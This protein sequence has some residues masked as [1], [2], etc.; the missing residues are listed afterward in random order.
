M[1]TRTYYHGPDA[2]VTDDQFVWMTVSSNRTFSVRELRNVGLVQAPA[3]MRSFAPALAV[4][5]LFVAVAGWSLMPTPAVM[6]AWR[7]PRHWELH[8][9]YHSQA[10]VLYSSSDARVFNQVSRALRRAMED[11]G[12][13]PWGYGLAAA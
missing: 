8:A 6:A 4:G 10:V 13:T 9:Q 11:S 1:R 7:K 5:V 3:R 12:R 2:M